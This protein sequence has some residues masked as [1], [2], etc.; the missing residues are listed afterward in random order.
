MSDQPLRVAIAGLGTIGGGVFKTLQGKRE[1]F[2]RQVGIPIEIAAVADQI[3]ERLKE[4]G[5]KSDRIHTDALELP[6]RNDV[7]LIV[8]LIGGI[9][10]AGQLIRKA[11]ESGKHV[12]TANKAVLSKC[13][14]DFA[15]LA[16]ENRV[17]LRFEASVAGGIPIIKA[18]QESL[19]AN[20]IESIR[21]ILNGTSNY[22]L[23]EM[24]HKGLDFDSA[25]KDAQ[26]KGFAEADPSLDIDGDDS[27]HKLSILASIAFGMRVLPEEI[28]MEGIRGLARQ[29][30]ENAREFGF[31]VKSLAIAKRRGSQIEA[32]VHPTLLPEEDILASVIREYNGVAVKGDVVGSTVYFGKGAGRYPTAS[33]VVADIMDIARD[34]ACGCGI[35]ARP[36]LPEDKISVLPMEEIESF[37]YL[38]VTTVDRPGALGKLGTILGDHGISVASA[39]QKTPHEE[40]LALTT[41]DE[42]VVPLVFFTHRA[43]DGNIRDAVREI[44]AL[45][46]IRHPTVVMHVEES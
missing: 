13:G 4:T 20:Q 14:S 16:A 45:D 2:P 33:A 12:V 22:I 23:H 43:R 18:L 9:E 27:V 10:V 8:E 30:I 6:E 5:L 25:L 41:P 26:E 24:T 3:E 28:Y 15:R 11:L 38:R 1:L 31:V 36:S 32:R 34:R 46:F 37:Y 39:L 7:D 19:A 21:G 29:D 35:P 44:D 42:A 40:M 17:S